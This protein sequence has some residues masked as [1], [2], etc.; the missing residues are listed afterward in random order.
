MEYEEHIDT[1][2]AVWS[3]TSISAALLREKTRSWGG[4]LDEECSNQGRNVW[5]NA[6]A[7]NAKAKHR[8]KFNRRS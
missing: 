7:K 2:W 1:R 5:R 8:K 6:R 3:K 4:F